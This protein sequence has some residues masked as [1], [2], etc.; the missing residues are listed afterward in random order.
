MGTRWQGETA[1]PPTPILVSFLPWAVSPH[2][3]GPHPPQIHCSGAGASH[4]DRG[5]W[6]GVEATTL[7][8]DICFLDLIAVK[9]LD[10]GLWIE[11]IPPLALANILSCDPC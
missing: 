4:E 2:S 8:K 5:L 9:V 10:Q 7:G 3:S 11:V 6:P 1:S